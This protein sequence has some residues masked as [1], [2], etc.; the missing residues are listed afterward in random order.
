M[1]NRLLEWLTLVIECART[2]PA[3]GPDRDILRVL[4]EIEKRIEHLRSVEDL[5]AVA[6]LSVSHFHAKFRRQTGI[7]PAEYL[8]R[9]KLE[10]AKAMLASGRHSV[11]ETAHR[12]GF[13]SSQYFA[14]VF[15]KFV[16]CTPRSFLPK[17]R[18]REGT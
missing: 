10:R 7:S 8:T 1:H 2:N 4:D 17:A 9:W 3:G 6:G 13:S 12:L 14:T 18:T 5:A 15:R 11:T 16:R